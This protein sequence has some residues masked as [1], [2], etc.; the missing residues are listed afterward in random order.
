MSHA[1]V[2]YCQHVT[3]W[4]EHH[5]LV[6]RWGQAVELL[7]AVAAVEPGEYERQMAHTASAVRSVGAFIGE[8]SE[9]CGSSQG[10]NLV[11]E[12][13]AVILCRWQV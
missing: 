12:V 4:S 5:Y 2:I 1:H 6:R 13:K 10:A 11:V 3:V 9:R 7:R 8:L